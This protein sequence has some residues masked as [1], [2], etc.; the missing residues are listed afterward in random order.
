M[1][2][3]IESVLETPEEFSD[4]KIEE[5]KKTLHLV[6]LV[7]GRRRL[8]EQDEVYVSVDVKYGVMR[9]GRAAYVAM[10]MDRHWYKIFF[11]STKCVIAW[12]VVDSLADSQA[13]KNGWRFAKADKTSNTI[14]I[15]IKRVIDTFPGIQKKTYRC[16]VQKYRD[17]KSLLGNDETYY[18]IEMTN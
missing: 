8:I 13:K 5:S 17:R 18:F 7:L 1:T 9:I 10:T 14:T 11:D 16:K 15:S 3:T 6:P 4:Y 2:T 12:T